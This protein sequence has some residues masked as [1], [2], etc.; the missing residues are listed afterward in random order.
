MTESAEKP[1]A[2]LYKK[3]VFQDK[4]SPLLIKTQYGVG[5]GAGFCGVNGGL[6]G[7][8]LGVWVGVSGLWL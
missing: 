2:E 4:D 1:A 8:C 7:G 6:G 3:A 5:A